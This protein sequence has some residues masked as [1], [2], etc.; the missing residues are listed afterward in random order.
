MGEGSGG[1]EGGA[2]AETISRCQN[3]KLGI[4]AQSKRS[5]GFRIAF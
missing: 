5:L 4:M 3:E 1:E 2:G